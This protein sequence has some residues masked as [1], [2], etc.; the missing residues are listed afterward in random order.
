MIRVFK[1]LATD[2]YS[3][4]NEGRYCGLVRMRVD[5]RYTAIFVP[6]NLLPVGR[7]FTSFRQAVRHIVALKA[8]E[9]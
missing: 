4:M 6:R 8:L 7:T 3:I 2:T 1:N 5:Q 9:S